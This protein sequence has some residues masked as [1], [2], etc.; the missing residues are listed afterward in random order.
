M[1][2]KL[3]KSTYILLAPLLLSANVGT[4]TA[5]DANGLITYT[6]SVNSNSDAFYRTYQGKEYRNFNVYGCQESDSGW[7]H[8]FPNFNLKDLNI[9]SAKLLISAYDVD[10]EPS[11]GLNGEYNQISIDQ[12]NLNPGF[13][14]G[15]NGT[16]YE[17]EFDIPLNYISDDGEMSVFMDVDIREKGWCVRVPESK[18]VLSYKIIEDNE[19][20]Y[21]AKIKEVLNAASN[22]PLVV[23]IL[24]S[25]RNGVLDIKNLDPDGDT[26]TYKYRWFVDV[27][28][29]EYVDADFAGKGTITTNTVP[30]RQVKLNEKWRVEVT[31]VDEHGAIGIATI[32]DFPTIAEKDSDNDSILDVNDEYPKD[33]KRAFNLYYPAK[34]EMNTLMYEDTW[35]STGDYDMNDVVINFNYKF[36]ADAKNLIKDIYLTLDYKAYGGI[37]HHGFALEMADLDRTNILNISTENSGNT[38]ELRSEEGHKGDKTVIIITED[39]I[40]YMPVTYDKNG[41]HIFFNTH[42]NQAEKS[43]ESLVLHIELDEARAFDVSKAPFNP[44]IFRQFNDP[45]APNKGRSHETHLIDHAPSDLADRD[46]FGTGDDKSVFSQSTGSITLGQ[47]YRTKNGLPWALEVS[48]EVSYPAEKTDFLNAYPNL[49]DWAQKG[50]KTNMDWHKHKN[51]KYTWKNQ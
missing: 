44:F 27:G 26:V 38:V 13:L 18:V 51:S 1:M 3:L 35:P 29:G 15:S 12:N 30:A 5:P 19:A 10:A 16:T 34:G 36:V 14:Q 39:L 24:G 45:L 46:L 23:T 50:G 48:G 20:P 8:N 41:S 42:N 7:K 37:L 43:I 25:D 2:K 32:Y 17:T 33:P 4:T 28:Q 31:P 49:W 11:H 22:N 40:K 47:F 6:Q 21:K 9:I